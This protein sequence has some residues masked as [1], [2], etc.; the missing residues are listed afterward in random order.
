MTGIN[1]IIYTLSSMFSFCQFSCNYGD[2][3]LQNRE[4]FC[5]RCTKTFYGFSCDELARIQ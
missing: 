3:I 4:Q 5:P 2:I 1:I